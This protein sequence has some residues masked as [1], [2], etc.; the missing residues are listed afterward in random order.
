[1]N[2]RTTFTIDSSGNRINYNTPVMFIGS[3]FASEIGARM[4]SGKMKVLINPAGVV[5]N[6]VSV[7]NTIDLII[8]NRIFGKRDLYNYKGL[9]LSFSHYTDFSSEDV[10]QALTKINS[11]TEIANNFLKHC[12]FL[13]I[14]FGTARVYRFKET[15]KIVS[16]CHKIPA[17]K[18][19]GEI[20]SVDEI[21][22]AWN[23]ILN[24]LHSFNK[25]L[26]VIFTISPVRHWK[27]GAHGN[28]VSKSVLFLAVEQ[29]LKHHI[30]EGY[31]PADELIMDDLRDYR[32]YSEDMLH[33]SPTAINYIWNAFSGCYFDSETIALWKEANSITKA[34]N[35]RFLSDSKAGKIEFANN[36]LKKIS[37]IEN[38]NSQIDFHEEKMYFFNLIREI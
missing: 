3:C 2:L 14:T 35:H 38:K 29:L 9:S 17:S 8:E 37:T 25:D 20:L 30:V 12:S 7:G 13:F 16:N 36:I 21:T 27:D 24:L 22:S 33:P 19:S 15:D 11:A 10:S 5:Y 4:D 34:R 26:R 28:Q 18:F 23:Y 1:M 6:P 31:F 32:F